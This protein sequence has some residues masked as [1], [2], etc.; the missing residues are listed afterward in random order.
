MEN[1]YLTPAARGQG[2]GTALIQAVAKLAME[3][4]CERV[5]WDALNSNEPSIK[6]FK[7]LGAR[8]L[9]DMTLYRLEGDALTKF[10]S[11]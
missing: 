4:G 10:A 8:P 9:S 2:A 5:E 3:R 1:L 7:K 11:S 6:F